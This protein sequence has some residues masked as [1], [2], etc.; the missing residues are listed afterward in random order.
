MAARRPAAAAETTVGAAAAATRMGAAAAVT[1][2]G[3]AAATVAG[4]GMDDDGARRA[5]RAVSVV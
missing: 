1:R 2:M 3:A 5:T 4:A